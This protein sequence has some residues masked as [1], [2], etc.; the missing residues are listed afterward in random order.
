M[1]HSS[2]GCLVKSAKIGPAWLPSSLIGYF[3]MHIDILQVECDGLK[4][5]AYCIKTR[6][7]EQFQSALYCTVRLC[8]KLWMEDHWS[9]CDITQVPS[10]GLFIMSCHPIEEWHIN[11]AK[12]LILRGDFLVIIS[13]STSLGWDIISLYDYAYMNGSWHFWRWF[14]QRIYDM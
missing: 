1:N 12:S 4:P 11:P 14:L 2:E 7:R 9:L 13:C 3:L 5:E 10:M 8:L 6:Y